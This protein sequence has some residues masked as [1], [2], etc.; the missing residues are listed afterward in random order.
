MKLAI[1]LWNDESGQDLVE[2]ALLAAFIAVAAGTIVGLDLV[3]AL[4]SIVS[5]VEQTLLR[6]SAKTY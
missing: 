3:P 6:S 4:G 2:Y 5:K 1:Q